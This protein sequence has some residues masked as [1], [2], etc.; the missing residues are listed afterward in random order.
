MS[1]QHYHHVCELL[2]SECVRVRACLCVREQHWCVNVHVCVVGYAMALSVRTTS[3]VLERLQHADLIE[4]K[5]A[6]G[7]D[8][9]FPERTQVYL[10][11]Y[12]ALAFPVA[13]RLPL[14]CFHDP[15]L[16]LL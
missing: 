15:C 1:G 13:T 12:P 7:S 16:W 11:H 5:T 6:L 8:C 14:P 9:T 4:T 3:I 10:A 2:L